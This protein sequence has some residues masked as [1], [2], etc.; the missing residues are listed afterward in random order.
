MKDILFSTASQKIW[1]FLCRHPQESFFSAQ[2]A[3]KTSLSKGGANQILRALTRQGLLL[4]EKKGRMVFYR[5]DAKSPLIRQFKVLRNLSVFEELT[6]KAKPLAERIILFGSCAR[7]E[8]TPESDMDVF[9]V[10]LE[11]EKIRSL[12]PEFK[13]KR[14]IQL[15]LKTPAEYIVLQDKEPVF[16]EELQ[17]G[18][19]LWEKE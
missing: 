12:I 6:K 19:V 18:I 10:G 15:V 14:K 8:D 16:Y 13:E 4:A 9:I 7:G 3:E 2:V 1:D 17:R 11:K 5:V